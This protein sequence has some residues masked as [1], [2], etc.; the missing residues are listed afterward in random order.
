M[1]NP[2]KRPW[3]PVKGA[4]LHDSALLTRIADRLDAGMDETA[5]V[6]ARAAITHAITILRGA[7]QAMRP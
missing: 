6:P 1:Y 3:N 5:T 2:A 7:S 4:E